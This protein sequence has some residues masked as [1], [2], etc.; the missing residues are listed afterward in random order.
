[1]STSSLLPVDAPGALLARLAEGDGS[2]GGPLF[3][4]LWPRVRRLAGRMLPVAA[5]ADDAAQDAMLTIFQRAADYDRSRPALPWAL[6]IGRFAC[7]SA[8]KARQRRREVP[9]E[10]APAAAAPWSD[11]AVEIERREQAGVV[12]AVVGALDAADRHALLGNGVEARLATPAALRKRRQRALER[13]RAA[14]RAPVRGLGAS[15]GQPRVAPAAA[16]ALRPARSRAGSNIGETSSA[17]V[18]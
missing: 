7:L 6:A 17:V 4:A 16:R 12:E 2:A 3:A 10:A 9:E 5:D 13:V 18:A 1:M 8:R 15:R 14:V 11:L